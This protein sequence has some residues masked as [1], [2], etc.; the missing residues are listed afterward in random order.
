MLTFDLLVEVSDMFLC[1][2]EKNFPF[3]I[4]DSRKFTDCSA[5]V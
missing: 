2:K 1:S 5:D 4:N 3:V